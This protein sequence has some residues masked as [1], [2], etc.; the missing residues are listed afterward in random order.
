MVK[1]NIAVAAF[2]IAGLLMV[3]CDDSPETGR[4][5][6]SVENFNGGAPVESD[7]VVDNGTDPPYVAE[8]L[9]PVTF[10]SRYYNDKFI[11]G[12]VRDEIIVTS[13]KIS[14][15]RTD[16][17]SGALATHTEEAHIAVPNDTPTDATIRLITWDDK[18]GPVLSPLMGSAN[19]I[20]MRA[21]IEFFGRELGTEHEIEF[22]ASV[23]VH[24]ADV[25]NL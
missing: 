10:T 5:I 6:V 13:Y 9:V 4:T 17:G 21:T 16:G 14:W 20:T 3:A 25:V 22:R 24:F 7:V 23:S 19:Q 12:E 15:E 18:S 11:T 1:H 8:D 2:A